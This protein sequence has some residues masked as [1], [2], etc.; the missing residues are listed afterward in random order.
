[1][2]G[3]FS[4]CAGLGLALLVGGMVFFGAVM[5]PLMFTRLPA[6]VAGP[7]V[8]GVFPFYFGFVA[9]G[10]GL[11][12]VGFAG[13]GE[14]VSAAVLGVVLAAVLWAW[15]WLVPAMDAWRAAGDVAAFTRGHDV[16]TWLNG[17]ELVAAVW[18]LARLVLAGT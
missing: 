8:R 5:A 12:L 11:G 2:R 3:A 6:G 10:A 16:S 14:R 1:M 15:W 4:V 18:L 9:A 17:A 7:F 13:R